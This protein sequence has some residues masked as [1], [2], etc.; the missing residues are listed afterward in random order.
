MSMS[1]E[2]D[3]VTER[4]DA[5][6]ATV[7]GLREQID[8]LES[9]TEAEGLAEETDIRSFVE[10]TGPDTHVH[11]AVALGAYL[12]EHEGANGFTTNN[13]ADGYD[14]IRTPKPA[15]PSDVLLRAEQQDLIMPLDSDGQTKRWQLAVGGETLLQ[16]PHDATSG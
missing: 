7:A 10:A 15:N 14:R 6:E 13:I 9:G 2:R 1:D 16:R 3:A 12:E 5:L 11:R 4:L 8:V